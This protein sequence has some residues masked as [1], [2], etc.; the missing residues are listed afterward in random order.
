MK[1]LLAFFVVV[2]ISFLAAATSMS[3]L[4]GNYLTEQRTREDTQAMDSLAAVFAPMIGN[5]DAAAVNSRLRESADGLDGRLLL[6]DSDGKVQFDSMNA[7]CGQRTEIP[8][9]LRVLTL[10]ETSAYGMHR[11]GRETVAAMTGEQD[12]EYLAYGAHELP[13]TG[14]RSGA[15]V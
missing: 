1:I 5:A 8:E 11:L 13:G 7:L 9:L 3:G 2:G 14:G 4:V 15:L 6:V 10:G 12:A